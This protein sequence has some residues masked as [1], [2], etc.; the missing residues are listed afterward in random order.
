MDRDFV[1]EYIHPCWYYRSCKRKSG[2][3]D[4]GEC[5]VCYEVYELGDSPGYSFMFEKGQH[6]SL[7]AS[8]VDMFW[9]VTDAI[10]QSVVDYQFTSAVRLMR[11]DDSGRFALAFTPRSP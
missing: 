3:C 4:V 7:S 6:D 9:Q 11:D 1:H 2:V 5:G 10:C 8:E